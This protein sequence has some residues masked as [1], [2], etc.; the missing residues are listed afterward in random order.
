VVSIAMWGVCAWNG[1]QYTG[2][3]ATSHDQKMDM[4][5]HN[6]QSSQVCIEL[7]LEDIHKNELKKP[8]YNQKPGNYHKLYKPNECNYIKVAIKEC[9]HVE[10]NACWKREID[11][12]NLTLD[13]LWKHG[14]RS[15]GHINW[16]EVYGNRRSV[17]WMEVHGYTPWSFPTGQWRNS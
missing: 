15:R 10:Q 3:E 2:K 1:V 14:W 5:W 4:F 8:G 11:V 13:W 7:W 9:G 17:K 6:Q 16:L 12:T